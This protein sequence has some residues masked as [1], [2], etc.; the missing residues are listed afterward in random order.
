MKHYDVIIIGGGV[1]GLSSAYY[2]GKAGKSVLVLDKGDGT[3]G[4]SFGNSGLISPSHFV[5][6]AAPGI[7]SKGLKWMMSRDSPFYVKPRFNIGLMKWGWQFMNHATSKHVEN[8]KQLLADLSL[9]SRNLHIEIAKEGDFP[10]QNKGMLMLCKEE[11]TLRHEIELGKQSVEMG[12]QT[13]ACTPAE[14]RELEPAMEL[15]VLGGV[16]FSTDSYIDP[17][18]FMRDL[19]SLLKP[20]D[21]TIIYKADVDGFEFKSGKITRA[22][23]GGTAYLADQFVLATGAFTPPLIKKLKL[24]LLLEGGKGYSVDWSAPTST[25]TMSYILAEARVAV[26]PFA[27][28]VRLAGTMEIVGLNEKVN[29]TRANGFIK[30]VQAYLPDYGFDK[31][32][33]LP[34]WVGLRPCS[35][36]G[37]PFVG[38]TS[39]FKNLI[40]ATGHAMMGFTLGPVTGLLVKEIVEEEKTSIDIGQL[41][42]NR[43]DSMSFS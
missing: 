37:L 28:R 6:L 9:L 29:K 2:L 36:D 14:L 27:D 40:L 24:N 21:V 19:P 17:A 32:K 35:P 20:M 30:S 41:A 33:N 13:K 42:A 43:Y 31:L 5:P 10:L 38:R 25:P 34:V 12:M 8:S 22:K 15:D 11:E 7:V 16:L 3:D 39:A 26:T 1:V 18:A 4:C 23:V